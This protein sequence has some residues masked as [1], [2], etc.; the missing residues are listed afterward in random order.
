M[1]QTLKNIDWPIIAQKIC[2][3]SKFNITKEHITRNPLPIEE[4]NLDNHLSKVD[5]LFNLISQDIDINSLAFGNVSDTPENHFFINNL[6]KNVT[7]DFK[8]LNFACALIENISELKNTLKT[9][10]R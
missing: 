7:G 1:H 6:V 3:F 10:D 4:A 5:E 2:F 9:Y 8:Q